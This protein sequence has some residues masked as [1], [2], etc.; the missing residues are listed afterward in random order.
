MEVGLRCSG[1]GTMADGD[2]ATVA[3]SLSAARRRPRVA[4][5]AFAQLTGEDDAAMGDGN[6]GKDGNTW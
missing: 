1:G 5:R 4:V 2:A 3:Q 6:G